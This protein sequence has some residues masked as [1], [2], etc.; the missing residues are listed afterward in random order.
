MVEARNLE[1]RAMLPGE[2]SLAAMLG[3]SIGTVRRA[4]EELRQRDLVVTLPAKG[5]FVT[6]RPGGDQDA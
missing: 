5:T 2:Q 1:P 3:V 6:R 4:T